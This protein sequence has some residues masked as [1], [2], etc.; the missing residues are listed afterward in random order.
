M[1][2]RSSCSPAT[3]G[4]RARAPL[5]LRD[6]GGDRASKGNLATSAALLGLA[7]LG[8]AV[9]TR[10]ERFARDQQR[11]G[12]RG[13]RDDA[14]RVAHVL[15]RVACAPGR[16]A[17]CRAARAGRRRADRRHGLREPPRG[18]ARRRSPT[19]STAPGR[20]DEAVEQALSAASLYDGEGQRRLR[21]SCVRRELVAVDA[22]GSAGRGR[23]ARASRIRRRPG[24]ASG[25]TKSV[26]SGVTCAAVRRRRAASAH[27]SGSLIGYGDAS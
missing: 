8:Q 12:L 23:A 14:G 1:P 27:V 26:D 11:S 19:C 9:T 15:A 2:G 22:D 7:L 3:S 4:R 5:G 20:S 10:P 16:R 6:A 18:R 21:P 13:R 24:L 17:R 25:G